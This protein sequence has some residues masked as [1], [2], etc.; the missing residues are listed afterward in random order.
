MEINTNGNQF[1]EVALLI[2]HY[3]RSKSLENLLA[4]FKNIHCSFGEIIVSDDGS[5]DKHLVKLQD[6]SEIYNFRLIKAVKNSGLG[7][8][9][10]KGQDAVKKPY[11][12]YIQEDFEPSADF[13]EVFCKSLNLLQSNQQ[14]DIIRFYA[15]APY[16]YVKPFNDQFDK[17]YFP[18]F[19]IRYTK[20]YA[21]SDHP[22]LRRSNFFNKFGR[23]PEGLK[24]DLTE[25]KMCISFLQ[26]N[27]QGLFYRDYQNLLKQ[28]NSEDEPSTM[29][30]SSWK[31][32]QDL[33]TTL[34]RDIYRQLKYNYDILFM[35]RLKGI[36]TRDKQSWN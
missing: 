22:H 11:T 27:G 15:Y 12:L 25:Y 17:L 2:T 18:K 21:Y 33:L 5:S 9:I 35:K 23:Y 29:E 34:T 30:R 7:N 1:N 32:N 36:Y 19:G 24:G 4:S 28:K 20:I 26:N 31:N 10:N 3:N 6:L 8:N 14:F 13:T 16:P